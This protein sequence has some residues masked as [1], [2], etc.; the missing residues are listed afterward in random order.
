[1]DYKT[2]A[3]EVVLIINNLCYM[4]KEFYDVK[5]SVQAAVQKYGTTIDEVSLKIADVDCRKLIWQILIDLRFARGTDYDFDIDLYRCDTTALHEITSY[6]E[7]QT[8]EFNR[9]GSTLID[10]S[11]L[12]REEYLE[13]IKKHDLI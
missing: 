8:T 9:E 13:Q 1:M 11:A 12:D 4:N 7:K 2:L 6:L 3:Q 5:S 10:I